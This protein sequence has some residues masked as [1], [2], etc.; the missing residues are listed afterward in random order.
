MKVAVNVAWMTPGQAGGM[1]YYARNLVRELGADTTHDYLL[2]TSSLNDQVFEAEVSPRWER[3]LHDGDDLSPNAYR[4]RAVPADESIALKLR[5]RQVDLVLCPFMYALPQDPD[6]PTIVTI[7]DLQHEHLPELFNPFELGSRLLG[8][9]RSIE[10]SVRVLAISEAVRTDILDTY[11]EVPPAKVVAT[12]LGINEDCAAISTAEATHLGRATAVRHRL[13]KPFLFYPANSW[14]HKNHLG[15]LEGFRLALDQGLDIELVLTGSTKD[16]ES[17]IGSAI[18]SHQLEGRVRHLG[19]V[20]R[21][22]IL[23]LYRRSLGLIL[24]SRFEGFGLPVLEAMA[25]GT[26][27]A[28]SDIPALREVGGDAVQYFDP[29]SPADIAT[30]IQTLAEPA[31]LPDYKDRLERFTYARTAARTVEVLAEVE[32]ELAAA[33]V[34]GQPHASAASRALPVDTSPAATAPLSSKSQGLAR[35]PILLEAPGIPTAEVH[36]PVTVRSPNRIVLRCHTTAGAGS[37]D[38]GARSVAIAVNGVV[39]SHERLGGNGSQE[40]IAPI[41]HIPFGGPQTASLAVLARNADGTRATDVVI[42][43]LF[44]DDDHYGLVRM[45]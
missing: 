20:S 21:N 44:V 19:Y 45:V 42:D 9:R 25:L 17:R 41:A 38:S 32:A 12:P 23:G 8:Y 13:T 16:F 4:R 39:G 5:A 31:P 35:Q 37:T 10:H 29:D 26:R 24:P 2:I 14:P 34:S 28:C 40:L 27:V 43:E 15:L 30:A 33:K 1:E 22:E 11:P 3:L 18:A 36:L 7:P 6:L